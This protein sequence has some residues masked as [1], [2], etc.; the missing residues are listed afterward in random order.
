MSGT[1]TN[2]YQEYDSLLQGKGLKI[3]ITKNEYEI[4]DESLILG[5][6]RPNNEFITKSWCVRSNTE[7]Q[8]RVLG[9]SRRFNASNDG[10]PAYTP[11]LKAAG[12]RRDGRKRWQTSGQGG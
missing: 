7:S 11:R 6:D 10:I 12:V 9:T 8:S 1:R 4:S 5:S 2:Y 3:S